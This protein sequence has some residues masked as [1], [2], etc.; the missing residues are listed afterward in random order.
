MD[1]TEAKLYLITLD[2]HTYP[3]TPTLHSQPLCG[4]RRG[5]VDFNLLV[6]Y[7]FIIILSQLLTHFREKSKIL[8]FE[9]YFIYYTP[10][11]SHTCASDYREFLSYV[12]MSKLSQTDETGGGGRGQERCVRWD[13]AI[14]SKRDK[15]RDERNKEG[16]IEE[17]TEM[18][19]EQ[20]ER[21]GKKQRYRPRETE[22]FRGIQSY[23]Q[24]KLKKKTR[25]WGEG[26]QRIRRRERWKKRKREDAER[27][28]RRWTDKQRF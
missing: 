13:R 16:E 9:D 3:H 23:R 1:W 19:R 4:G 2:W 27:Q 18:K 20:R 25:R 24:G 15:H 21:G 14:E 26:E 7:V 5:P 22:T 11:S 8:I 10:P 17:E 12:E 28:R 6:I